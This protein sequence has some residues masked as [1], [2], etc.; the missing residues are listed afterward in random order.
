MAA[1]IKFI[2]PPLF[3]GKEEEDVTEWMERYEKIGTYNRWGDAEKRAHVEL[4]LTGAA[5]KWFSYK[6]KAAQLAADWGTAAGPPVVIGLKDQI[7]QQFTPVNRDQFNETRLRERKQ[8]PEE[9]TVEF[10]YD[11]LDLCGKVD[12]NMAE[13]VKLQHLWRG[14]KPSLVEKFW[15][16]KPAT[17]DEFLTEV[18]RYQEMTSKSRHEEW[19]MGM[20]G[21][22]MPPVENDRLDRL[23]KMLEGLMGAIGT[24]ATEKPQKKSGNQDDAGQR[25]RLQWAQDGSPTVLLT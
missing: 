9:S 22:Q 10:F 5:Q 15:S 18:K 11:V 16:M 25:P 4:S 24:K 8:G 23:E 13:Q 21:K 17:T 12:P 1:Q 6:G 20:L 2:Q 7:L 19:A 3:A 14:I